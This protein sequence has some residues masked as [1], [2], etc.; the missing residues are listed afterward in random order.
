MSFG[1]QGLLVV[2][3]AIIP[4]LMEALSTAGVAYYLTSMPIEVCFALAYC[5][6]NT[7]ASILV[8]NMLVLN[9]AGFGRKKGVGPTLIAACA[10]D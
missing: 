4:T 9:E 2:L 7:A 6:A 3:L 1:G 8:P 5:L 10:F